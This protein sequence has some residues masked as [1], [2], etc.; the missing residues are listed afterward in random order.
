[1]FRGTFRANGLCHDACGGFAVSGVSVH[2][3][4]VCLCRVAYR[5]VMAVEDFGDVLDSDAAQSKYPDQVEAS[6]YG[7]VVA[8]GSAQ[9]CQGMALLVKTPI[10]VQKPRNNPI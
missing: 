3:C 1:M 7:R 8:V 9:A 2:H 10:R 5:G 4:A 6:P